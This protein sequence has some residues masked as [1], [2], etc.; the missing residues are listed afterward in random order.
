MREL[1]VSEL[2]FVAG[3]TGVCT[4]H[5]SGGTGNNFGGVRNTSGIQQ[6]LIN[7]YEGLIGATSHMIERVAKAL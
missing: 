3:G 2:D 4:P 1:T 6:D 7:I 5:N